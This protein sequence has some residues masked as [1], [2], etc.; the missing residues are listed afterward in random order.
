MGINKNNAA[1]ASTATCRSEP[2]PLAPS[3]W[4]TPTALAYSQNEL[5]RSTTYY[6]LLQ[7]ACTCS[8]V[9]GASTLHSPSGGLLLT[10]TPK[11]ADPCI[12][13]SGSGR[14]SYHCACR[15]V[16]RQLDWPDL[17]AGCKHERCGEDGPH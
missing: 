7:A 17:H 4:N 1:L 8:V 16:A 11:T 14:A 5:L 3:P 13:K 10:F 12:S 15:V 9:H 6:H 2:S